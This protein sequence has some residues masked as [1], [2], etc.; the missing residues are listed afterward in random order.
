MGPVRLRALRDAVVGELVLAA[1]RDD[2]PLRE[3]QRMGRLVARIDQRL[4]DGAPV[5]RAS[6]N[7]G[8]PLERR[9]QLDAERRPSSMLG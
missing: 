3:I 6:L 4:A 2:A 9:Q 7:S 5:R 1:G 8:A